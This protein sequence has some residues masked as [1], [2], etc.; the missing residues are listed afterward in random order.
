[1]SIGDNKNTLYGTSYVGQV[2]ERRFPYSWNW[3]IEL[4]TRDD[5]LKVLEA[6]AGFY[7]F[8]S[9]GRLADINLPHMRL[10]IRQRVKR[11]EFRL[12][13]YPSKGLEQLLAYFSDL[14][15][16]ESDQLDNRNST[17]RYQ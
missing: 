5:C 1:M 11:T 10:F 16:L 3:K 17:A 15:N 8:V 13:K 4:W 7:E 14:S 9:G 12:P 2:I 6:V